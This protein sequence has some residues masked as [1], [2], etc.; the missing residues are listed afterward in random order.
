M[1]R[2]E[3]HIGVYVNRPRGSTQLQI[4]SNNNQI[5]MSNATDED[6]SDTMNEEKFQKFLGMKKTLYAQKAII[7]LI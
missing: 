5:D 1:C 3:P 4:E 7:Q 2:V 6:E